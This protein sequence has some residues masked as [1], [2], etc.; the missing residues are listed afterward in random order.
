[1][2]TDCALTSR[3]RS[4]LEPI[5]DDQ[6]KRRVDK[7]LL[8][9]VDESSREAAVT[10]ATLCRTRR[11]FLLE[12][13]DCP[14]ISAR[15]FDDEN[16]PRRAVTQFIYHGSAIYQ[17]DC[18]LR[19][20][21]RNNVPRSRTARFAPSVFTLLSRLNQVVS[22][23]LLNVRMLVLRCKNSHVCSLMDRPLMDLSGPKW[24]ADT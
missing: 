22:F 3:Y 5:Y 7:C 17:I 11:D 1:M 18:Q 15:E 24:S 19:N 21:P 23:S 8:A 6:I 2:S 16:L 20:S 9:Y 13:K 10:A 14:R 4:S 12:N